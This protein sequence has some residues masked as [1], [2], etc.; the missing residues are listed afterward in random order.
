M[1]CR[2]SHFSR[3]LIFTIIPQKDMLQLYLVINATRFT[4]FLKKFESKYYN[5]TYAHTTQPAIF[6]KQFT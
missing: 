1:R 2:G 6:L 3:H 5:L 4:I